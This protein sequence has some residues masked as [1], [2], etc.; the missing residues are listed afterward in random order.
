VDLNTRNAVKTKLE[1]NN[2]QEVDMRLI[3]SFDELNIPAEY[4]EYLDEYFRN[5]SDV[6]FISRVILFGSCAREEVGEYSDIDILITT[7][8][9]VTDDDEYLIAC[10]CRPTYSVQSIPMDI[11]VQDEDTFARHENTFGMVQ[12]Q[13]MLDGVDLSGLIR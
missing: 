7:D 13:A 2:C 10:E 9:Q 4:K 1:H 8:R 12:R 3:E 11:I 6:P 5:L